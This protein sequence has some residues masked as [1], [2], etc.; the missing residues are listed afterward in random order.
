M[1][2]KNANCREWN[3]STKCT[4]GLLL[5]CFYAFVPVEYN[6][7]Q[8]DSQRLMSVKNM[9][10]VQKSYLKSFSSADNK[11]T[12][13]CHQPAQGISSFQGLLT[14]FMPK[15]SLAQGVITNSY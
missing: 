10:F 11:N 7:Y 12:P 5:V 3:C 14:Y 1:L 4:V 6:K 15:T 2:A 9:F 8:I 13:L